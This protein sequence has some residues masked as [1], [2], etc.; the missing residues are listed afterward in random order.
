[1]KHINQALKNLLNTC[2]VG[3]CNNFWEVREKEVEE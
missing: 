2:K 3:G 1:M